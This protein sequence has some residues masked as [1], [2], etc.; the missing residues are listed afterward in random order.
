MSERTN[1]NPDININSFR[2]YWL[3]KL[4]EIQENNDRL[5]PLECVRIR[6]KVHSMLQHLDQMEASIAPLPRKSASVK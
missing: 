5:S 6:K 3:R 1:Q 4:A 2:N